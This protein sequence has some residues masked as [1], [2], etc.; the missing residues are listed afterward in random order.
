MKLLFTGD[1]VINRQYDTNTKIDKN[2]V[3]LFNS[4]DINVVNLEAPITSSN[5]KILKTGPHLKADE[6]STLGVLKSLNINLVTLANNHILDYDEQGVLD[7]LAFCKKN[8]IETVGAGK[9]KEEASNVFNLESP[10]GKIA[11]INISE[12][13]WASATDTSAGANGMDLIDDVKKIQEV[14]LK[15]NFVIVVVHGGYEYYNLPSPRMQKQYRFYIDKGADLVISHHTHCISGSET[16]K[17]K[18]I[19]YSLGNFIFTK[20]SKYDDWYNGLVLQVDIKDGIIETSHFFVKQNRE[21]FTLSILTEE[22]KDKIVERFDNYSKIIRNTTKLKKEWRGFISKKYK[23]YLNYWSPITFIKN[24]YFRA[25]FN[26]LNLRF[27]NKKSLSLY[28]NLMRCEA[29]SD[30]SKEVILKY[31]KNDKNSHTPQKR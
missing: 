29:H 25:I 1:L 22:E 24:R 20:H 28:L 27:V 7:T 14:K 21:T 26:R 23:P 30:I 6:D 11:I 19:Y 31:L 16:Y 2:I 18:K 10:E 17:G 4:S 15:S 8:S 3:D 5:K 13:E 12:N 9:N